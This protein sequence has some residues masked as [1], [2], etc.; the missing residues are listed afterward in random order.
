M[1][2]LCKPVGGYQDVKCLRNKLEYQQGQSPLAGI[3]GRRGG[4]RRREKERGGRKK[5]RRER[6]ERGER[7]DVLYKNEYCF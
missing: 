5:R 3:E 6:G 1:A 7:R 2:I 4:E